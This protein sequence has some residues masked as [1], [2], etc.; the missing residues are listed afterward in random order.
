MNYLMPLLRTH[1]VQDVSYAV[2]GQK[3]PAAGDSVTREKNALRHL[4]AVLLKESKLFSP[5]L[6]QGTVRHPHRPGSQG[7]RARMPGAPSQMALPGWQRAWWESPGLRAPAV[8]D[9]ARGRAAGPARTAAPWAGG[10]LPP[11]SADVE[12]ERARPACYINRAIFQIMKW[13]FFD[14]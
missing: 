2:L 9:C 8:R 3:C 12:A 6:R 14:F 4:A 11:S 10:L 13:L 5:N 1:C 7:A